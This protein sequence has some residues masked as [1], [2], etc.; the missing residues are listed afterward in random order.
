MNKIGSYNEISD[1]SLWKVTNGFLNPK[2]PTA[3]DVDDAFQHWEGLYSKRI[4]PNECDLSFELNNWLNTDSLDNDTIMCPVS[5]DELVKCINSLANNKATGLDDIPNE[6]YKILNSS[7]LEFVLFII[8]ECLFS[9]TCPKSWKFGVMTFIHKKGDKGDIK[10][11]RPITLLNHFRKMLEAILWIRLR[12]W[13]EDNNIIALCQAGFRE[14]RGCP[15]QT[16]VLQ[17]AIDKAKYIKKDV[18]I[19]FLDLKNAYDSVSHVGLLYK[20]MKIGLSPKFVRFIKDWLI[21]MKCSIFNDRFERFFTI[22]R[23]VPQGSILSPF[24]FNAYINDLALNEEIHNLG[25][26]LTGEYRIGSIL[27]ADDTALLS[28]SQNEAQTQLNIMCQWSLDWGLS[29]HP[30]KT[31]VMVFKFDKNYNKKKEPLCLGENIILNFCNSFKYLGIMFDKRSST[32]GLQNLEKSKKKFNSLISL[33]SKYGNMD[34]NS[35]TRI[36]KSILRS[37]L[38]YGC[39]IFPVRREY[40]IFQRNIGKRILG[41]YS[42]IS[43]RLVY[44]ILGWWRLETFV[45]KNC[46]N[47]AQRVVN[48]NY[49]LARDCAREQLITNRDNFHFGWGDRIIKLLNHYE[50]SLTY[51]ND[52]NSI[53][54]YNRINLDFKVLL[55][56][57]CLSLESQY[58]NEDDKWSENVDCLSDRKESATNMVRFGKYFVNYGFQ[59]V[60]DNYNPRDIEITKCYL[61]N[62]YNNNNYNDYMDCPSHVIFECNFEYSME[63]VKNTLCDS[64][65]S[66]KSLFLSC[67]EDVGVIFNWS[68]LRDYLICRNYDSKNK[69]NLNENISSILKLFGIFY[70]VRSIYRENILRTRMI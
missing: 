8:N 43:T 26:N 57:K 22:E 19:T 67:L 9:E 48:S 7:S 35:L 69:Q 55:N 6:A 39:E 15:E 41:T 58:W 60:I 20:L 45:S 17:H 56:E 32:I 53:K 46:L 38:I 54:Q 34:G 29:I 40:E 64:R 10:N 31:E 30:G 66:L 42:N 47:F 44:A 63:S 23:G 2:K 25:V 24:L 5:K 13:S 4:L 36:F 11:Y 3:F 28:H 65:E 61:C 68:N 37:T 16:L 50:I 21:G 62:N 52:N 59:F 18:W 14:R 12:K 51:L 70:R 1:E 49:K 27:Y 33:F